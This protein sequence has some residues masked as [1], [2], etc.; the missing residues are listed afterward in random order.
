M[1]PQSLKLNF[2][3][4]KQALQLI[5]S[6]QWKKATIVIDSQAALNALLL[7]KTLARIILVHHIHRDNCQLKEEQY[8]VQFVWVPGRTR[9]PRNEFA[10][11]VDKR[12]LKDCVVDSAW[13]LSTLAVK[14]ILQTITTDMWD[15]LW[16]ASATSKHLKEV[17][18]K[19]R[20]NVRKRVSCTRSCCTLLSELR[21]GHSHLNR[22]THGFRLSQPRC[23]AALVYHV[24]FSRNNPIGKF[25]PQPAKLDQRV[26]ICVLEVAV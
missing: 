4:L 2:H 6:N 12:A 16:K 13:P 26:K 21:T 23:A 24:H 18:R 11:T 17:Q 5:S 22:S 20:G 8:G 10:D 25:Y 7:A 14:G 9:I 3:G 19:V 1:N 15:K